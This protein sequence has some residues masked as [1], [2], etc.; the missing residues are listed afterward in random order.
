VTD[1]LT[2]LAD[3]EAAVATRAYAE[4]TNDAGSEPLAMP[5][6]RKKEKKAREALLSAIADRNYRLR[7]FETLSAEL[8]LPLAYL[9]DYTDPSTWDERVAAEPWARVLLDEVRKIVIGGLIRKLRRDDAAFVDDLIRYNVVGPA[10]QRLCVLWG[11][12]ESSDLLLLC[13][14]MVDH[15]PPPDEVTP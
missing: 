2:L 14:A 1:I 3:Y 10:L 9:I 12:P 5:P 6:L 13:R 11:I 7:M 4:G 15:E 8:V